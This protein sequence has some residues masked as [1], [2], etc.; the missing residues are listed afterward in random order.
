M[1]DLFT[2]G[3]EGTHR[4]GDPG[5][6]ACEEGYPGPCRCG[7]LVHASPTEDQDPD[8]NPILVTACDICGR[9]EDQIDEP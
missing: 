2:L 8:G 9:A 3:V 5:C 1:A 7:G 4:V 6:P